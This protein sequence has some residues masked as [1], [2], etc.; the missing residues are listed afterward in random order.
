MSHKIAL[1]LALF[2]TL[3]MTGCTVDSPTPE[4]FN[5]TFLEALPGDSEDDRALSFHAPV[6]SDISV[7]FRESLGGAELGSETVANAFVVV[8][9][10]RVGAYEEGAVVWRTVSDKPFRLDLTAL[11]EGEVEE[12]ARGPFSAGEYAGIAL[13][14]SDAWV[15]DTSGRRSALELPGDA[16]VIRET[17]S[18]YPGESTRLVVNFGALQ[19]LEADG[20]SW[21]TEP[22]PS[23]EVED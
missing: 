17:F 9:G 21:A 4:D 19:H 11:A 20:G 23:L 14:I 18:L 15:V 8:Q 5:D 12:L 13:G 22:A 7:Q 10:V 6:D 3:G 16:L 1:C 2:A